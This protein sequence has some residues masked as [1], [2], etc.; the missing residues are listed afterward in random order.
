[1]IFKDKKARNEAT[2]R[3]I[4]LVKGFPN[5]TSLALLD[6]EIGVDTYYYWSTRDELYLIFGVNFFLIRKE[7]LPLPV[8]YSSFSLHSSS[9][10]FTPHLI[11]YA[12]PIISGLCQRSHFRSELLPNQEAILSLFSNY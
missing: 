5:T 11:A 10:R 9:S 2:E 4:K 3:I 6:T 8:Y 12:S 1:L 7:L